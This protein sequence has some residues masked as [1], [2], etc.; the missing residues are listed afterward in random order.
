MALGF[1]RRHRRWLY[2]FLWLVIAAF[3]I[4]Y[5]P[6]F[7]GETVGSPGETLARVGGEPISVGEYQRSYLRQRSFYERMYQGRGLDASMLRRLGLEEQ[8]FRSLV[9][10][11]LV[12]L[13][14]RRLGL[15]VPDSAVAKMLA[16]APDFQEDGKFM[17]SA[18]IKRR[19]ELQGITISEF[20]ASL[21]NRMLRDQLEGLVTEGVGVS[22]AE[23][24]AEYRRRN[25]QVKAEY[26]LVE[27]ARFRPGVVVADDEVKA[28]FDADRESL[29]LPEKRVVSYL[30]V[31]GDGLRSRVTVTDRDLEAYY[32]EHRDELKEDEQAC[33]SH[34]LVKVKS[35]PAAKEGHAEAEAKT[36]AEG[37][38]ARVKAGGD[39]AEIA[40]K[41]SEDQ[42]SAPGGG[43][44]GCFPKGRMVPQFDAAVFALS[45]GQTSE[46]VRSSFGYHIIR[47]ASLREEQTPPL[48]AVKER[49]RPLAT[50][51]K[52]EA[53]AAEKTEAIA[54]LLAKGR[55]LEDAGK[56]HGFTVQKSEPI[57]RGE[58]KEPLASPGLV[59][60]VFEQ[61]VGGIEKEGFVV[62]RGVAFV[63]LT[64]I[65]PSRLP[66]LAD[67]QDKLR[68]TI[69]D[70]KAFALAKAEA[71]AVRATAERDGLEKAA[72]SRKLVRKETPGLVGRGQ[73]L[74]DLG[75]GAGL[76]EAAFSLPEKTLSE[77]VRTQGGYAVIRVVEKKAFDPAAFV[78][79]KAS[80]EAGLRQQKQGQL[81]QAYLSEARDRYAIER[82]A[83]A[84][85][86]VMGR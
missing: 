79:E 50:S 68:S 67:V 66:E 64:E 47:L 33:A 52:V 26:V 80:L 44:L 53:L 4:L 59:A 48:T 27:A 17:G 42:G 61:K 9:E 70:E 29:R 46:L 81:F 40:K 2:V 56:E 38:L 49:I 11:R 39:F 45:P 73:P 36:I 84:F 62:P 7:Q 34:I 65:Q 35:D 74:G 63:A 51:Q 15:R 69:L 58:V 85:K 78:R 83:E 24:E 57:A 31:D 30:L 13:E 19:L 28:R 25:E 1:M 43:D 22:D 55:S 77:P 5:I 6:A 23:A 82:N 21:R 76:E 10:D 16:T 18:E 41:S 60:R 75:T 8:V 14:A 54:G 20:E 86:R 32:Q 37:L 3:I 71:A 12:T 72:T